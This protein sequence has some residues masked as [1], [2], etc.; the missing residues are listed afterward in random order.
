MRLRIGQLEFNNPSTNQSNKGMWLVT[1][2]EYEL[3]AALVN[4]QKLK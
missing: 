3:R 4:I 2:S 1:F